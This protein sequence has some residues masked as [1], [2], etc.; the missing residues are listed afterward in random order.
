LRDFIRGRFAP[1][2]IFA[3]LLWLQASLSGENLQRIQSLP[4]S[5]WLVAILSDPVMHFLVFGLFTL[6]VCLGFYRKSK[7]SI[8]IV[9]VAVVASGYSLLIELYQ[10]I[11]PWRS[12]GLDDLIWNTAGVLFFLALVG[13]AQ[14]MVRNKKENLKSAQ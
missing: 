14:L 7:W 1:A 12:M 3:L 5:S 6:L 8:P 11:L 4:N 10:A 9:K 13:A 2:R